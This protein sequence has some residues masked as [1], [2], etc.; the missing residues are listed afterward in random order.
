MNKTGKSC[1]ENKKAAKDFFFWGGGIKQIAI[2][3]SVV[4]I[5]SSF[6]IQSAS[7]SCSLSELQHH[8]V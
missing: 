6:M 5:K 1:T 8:C 4:N 7:V 2:T 3:Q